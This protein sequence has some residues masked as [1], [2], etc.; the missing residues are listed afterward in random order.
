MPG[1]SRMDWTYELACS[2]IANGAR[3]VETWLDA[4]TKA[5][6][7]LPGLSA[8]QAR[9]KVA[10]HRATVTDKTGELFLAVD[11]AGWKKVA[12]SKPGLAS[13]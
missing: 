3:D 2:G 9:L 6:R 7:D 12:D 5:W 11:A 10:L 1:E 8:E 13:R 4:A